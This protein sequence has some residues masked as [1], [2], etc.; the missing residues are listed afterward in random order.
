[1]PFS[2]PLWIREKIILLMHTGDLRS[3]FCQHILFSIPQKRPPLLL[4]YPRER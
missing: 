2:P 3:V 1:M 4:E